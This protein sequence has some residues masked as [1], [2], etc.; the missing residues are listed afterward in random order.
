[1]KSK[2]LIYAA[3]LL[4]AFITMSGTAFAADDFSGGDGSK[5]NPYR[6]QTPEQLQ[7]IGK[8]EYLDSHFIL[9]EDI[10]LSEFC[11]REGW[12]PIGTSDNPFTGTF[13]GASHTISGL[14][15]DE[16]GSD[17]VGLF[18][19]AE[20]AVFS[21]LTMTD[22]FLAGNLSAGSLAG[23]VYDGEFINCSVSGP[24][25]VVIVT[26]Y[27]YNAGGLVGTADNNSVFTDCSVFGNADGD[28]TVTS[29]YN[30]GGLVGYVYKSILTNCSVFGND[31]GAVKITASDSNAAGLVGYVFEEIIFTDC[32][33]F[34]N[35]ADAVTVAA[36]Y[37]AGGLVGSVSNES[38]FI[39]CSVFGND[40]GAVTIT[41]KQCAGGL[42]GSVYNVNS[43]FSNGEFVG[44]SV[45]GNGSG[46]VAVVTD[47]KYAGGLVGSLKGSVQNCYSD[48]KVKGNDYAGG[49]IGFVFSE[50]PAVTSVTHSYFSGTVQFEDGKNNNGGLYGGFSP[51]SDKKIDIVDSFYLKVDGNDQYYKNSGGTPISASDMKK[52]TT[53]TLPS[54]EGGHLKDED[55]EPWDIVSAD[56]PDHT[57]FITEG[58]TYPQFSSKYIPPADNNNTSGNSGTGTGT[59]QVTVI[60][61]VKGIK[62]NKEI[63]ASKDNTTPRTSITESIDIKTD[64]E[65]D[66]P[67]NSRNPYFL[68]ILGLIIVII[69]VG[70]LIHKN[71]QN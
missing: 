49:L 60:D 32:S 16:P 59:G 39:D 68:I 19:Y 25:S 57:W 40:T 4:T 64:D 66:P 62:E 65:T 47:D 9:T 26:D 10:N 42:A 61:P 46:T 67:E 12:I 3:V 70:Y 55:S 13:D 33:V 38:T 41:A 22:I 24:V 27:S 2:F 58:K 52:I 30:G 11:K 5:N 7:E 37:Y 17:N 43:V 29:Y 54:G 20:N 51:G 34:G 69:I 50:D 6:I 23:T 48:A 1:M 31:A 14:K 71:A 8:T 36:N 18:G 44:C 63:P 35:D 28:I 15:I 53:F 56:D 21:N 45:S